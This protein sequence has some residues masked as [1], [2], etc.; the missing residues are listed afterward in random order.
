MVATGTIYHQADNF[1]AKHMTLGLCVGCRHPLVEAQDGVEF[2]K[3]DCR[4]ERGSS[5]FQVITGPNMGGKSTY[6]RQ[7]RGE[8]LL[9]AHF[10]RNCSVANV[11]SPTGIAAAAGSLHLENPK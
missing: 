3:N 4:M 10:E 6:I 1:A 8:G 7:V 2:I 5:W 9:R 11:F